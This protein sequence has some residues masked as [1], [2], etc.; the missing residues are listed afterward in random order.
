[1]HFD[2]HLIRL[3]NHMVDGTF[4]HYDLSPKMQAMRKTTPLPLTDRSR[5]KRCLYILN[6]TEK[7]IKNELLW[8]PDKPEWAFAPTFESIT[9]LFDSTAEDSEL[10]GHIIN[11]IA[12][13]FWNMLESREGANI[14]TAP[15][16]TAIEKMIERTATVGTI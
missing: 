12:F 6:E 8:G 11:R 15:L 10:Y 14:P 4:R 2:R 7:L 1:M 3:L 5:K 13:V 9:W 16:L